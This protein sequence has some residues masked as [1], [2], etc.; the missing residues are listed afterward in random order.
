MAYRCAW[1]GDPKSEQEVQRNED[2]ERKLGARMGGMVNAMT[3]EEFKT[4]QVAGSLPGGA[5]RV[6]RL[7]KGRVAMEHTS[8][9]KMVE[10]LKLLEE[11]ATQKKDE[12]KNV[13][14]DKYTNLKGVIVAAESSLGRSLS[15]A[16]RHA[17]EAAVHA[18]DVGI[19]KARG[20]S[21]QMD[22][23][24]HR[25]PWRCIGGVALVGLLL[26]Y[27]LGRNRR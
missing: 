20:L 4:E 13:L 9:E 14:S 10:A 17:V 7:R 24:V 6:T 27:V 25:N 2:Y 21:D 19:G 18:K 26:G 3:V 15:D 16:G 23:S 8:G 12:L 5:V 22:K 11:A 1:K